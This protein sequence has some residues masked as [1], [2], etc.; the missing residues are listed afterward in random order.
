MVPRLCNLAF[1]AQQVSQII[2]GFGKIFVDF[3]GRLISRYRLVNLALAL[4]CHTQIQQSRSECWL[5]FQCAF[6]KTHGL[7]KIATILE[8]NTDV[9][10]D[11]CPLRRQNVGFLQELQ[12]QI[13]R[14]HLTVNQGQA[15]QYI[16]VVAV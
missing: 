8:Q 12:S 15:M 3:Q 2:V 7:R 5:E 9:V 4:A 16:H 11:I 6:V 10:V 13:I 14:P 1:Q